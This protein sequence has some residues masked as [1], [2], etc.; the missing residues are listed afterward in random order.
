[1]VDPLSVV[2]FG[3]KAL[4][5][6]PTIKNIGQHTKLLEAQTKE[7]EHALS[8]ADAKEAWRRAEFFA[9]ALIPS[10]NETLRAFASA[11]GKANFVV[12]GARGVFFSTLDAKARNELNTS[13]KTVFGELL[14]SSTLAIFYLNEGPISLFE[15]YMQAYHQLANCIFADAATL[16]STKKQSE[17]LAGVF[18]A[19]RYAL[20]YRLDPIE[21]LRE[22]QRLMPL[23]TREQSDARFRALMDEKTADKECAPNGKSVEQTTEP[24]K[25]G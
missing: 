2:G 16:E 25:T 21:M 12:Q 23:D 19:L 7:L 15:E 3:K 17:K 24:K 10:A 13:V 9:Q 5:F 14:D 20:R 18:G 22:S 6:V 8:K 4:E 11:L 1:M